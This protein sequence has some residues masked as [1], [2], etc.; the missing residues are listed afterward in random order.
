M[1]NALKL[2][3]TGTTVTTG[4]ASSAAV[5]LPNTDSGR[6]AKFVRIT[7]NGAGYLRFGQSGVGAATANDI[8]ITQAN[9]L[10]LD[11]TGC[12][13][14]RHIQQTAAAQINIVPLEI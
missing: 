4:A 13:H 1:L 14:F 12:T 3:T 2:S 7:S 6:P 10:I 9:D 8:M 11:I 5:A